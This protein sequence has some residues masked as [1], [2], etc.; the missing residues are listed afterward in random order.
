M[1]AVANYLAN[2]W[3]SDRADGPGPCA[4][5]FEW[6]RRRDGYERTPLVPLDRTAAE[7]GLER[8]WA[9]DETSRF[10]LSSFKVLGASWAIERARP[11]DGTTL[12]TATDGN[13]GKAVAALA[14]TLGL[15]AEIL[16]PHDTTAARI[17]AIERVGGEVEVIDGSYDEA[18]ATAARRAQELG[19]DWL[20]VSDTALDLADPI[21]PW[22]VEGYSTLYFEVD[23][24]LAE[25][26]EPEPDLVLL[27]I[28]VGGL[29]A[30]GARW[31][32]TRGGAPTSPYLVG[33][34]PLSAACAQASIA[35]GAPATVD[36]HFDS[37][38]VGLNA[39]TPSLSAWEDLKHGLDGY[40]AISDHWNDE[41]RAALRAGGVPAGDTGVAGLAALLAMRSL[42]DGVVPWLREVRRP[43]VLVTEGDP[44]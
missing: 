23:E 9:K 4:E 29:A 42:E 6:H 7:L 26:R 24:A 25:L 12:V 3:R 30:A 31:F 36:G 44:T 33:V 28:G 20:L 2:P 21:P 38:M 8:L 13:H 10:G 22:I 5:A 37:S 40:I 15:R 11:R 35:A 41:A 14:R 1:A 27:P 32:R 19:S 18:V 43:L 39:G 17:A 16:V 34:E